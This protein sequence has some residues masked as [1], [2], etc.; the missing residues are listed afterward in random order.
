MLNGKCGACI[1]LA[2]RRHWRRCCR[3]TAPAGTVHRAGANSSGASV[4]LRMLLGACPMPSLRIAAPFDRPRNATR[5]ALIGTVAGRADAADERIAAIDRKAARKYAEAARQAR[6]IGA[7]HANVGERLRICRS[8]CGNRCAVDGQ[9]ETF[10]IQNIGNR[11]RNLR[12]VRERS[13][14]RPVLNGLQLAIGSD[15]GPFGA[16]G[17]PL[18]YSGWLSN[19]MA[20]SE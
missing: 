19:P 18:G 12:I 11:Q 8:R 7:A 4:S 14:C 9:G 15:S 10:L 1:S 6:N 20:R 17:T 2:L 3:G 13:S 5:C 16:P